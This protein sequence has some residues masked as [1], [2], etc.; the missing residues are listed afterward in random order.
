MKKSRGFTLIELLVVISVIAILIAILMPALNKSK[1]TAKRLSCA[2]RIKQHVLALNLWASNNDGKLPLPTTAGGWLQDV[3]VNTVNFMLKTGMTKDMFYCPSNS[4]HQKYKDLF[5]MYNNKT[6]DPVKNQFTN[7]SSSSFICSGYI[8]ILQLSS[9][10][11]PTI[12]AYA[13]DPIPKMWVK[14]NMDSKP[15]MRELV[16]DWIGGTPQGSTKYGYN[17]ERI[18]GGIYSESK[19]YDR[20]SHLKNSQEPAGGNIGF[21]DGHGEWRA[22]KPET[23][24]GTAKPRYANNPG[25]FW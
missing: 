10:S 5:W 3:A 24:N 6:W 18:A 8:Y 11:R 9:G 25:F 7:E 1:E 16:V 17:F 2:M 20:S 23:Q 21:L 13:N 22:F 12:V 19:V 4:T 14:T 15:A